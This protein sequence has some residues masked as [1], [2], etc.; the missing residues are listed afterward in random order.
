MASKH[1]LPYEMELFRTEDYYVMLNSISSLW[2]CRKT[3]E[4]KVKPG[5]ELANSGDLECL[6]IFY[7]LIGKIEFHIPSESRLILI[8]TVAPVGEIPGGRGTVHKICSIAFLHP[9]GPDATVTDM[10]LKFCRKHQTGNVN[11]PAA[12]AIVASPVFE[13]AS[14]VK[15]WGTI[16]SATSSIKNTTQQAAAI[17]SSQV[18]GNKKDKEK[19]KEKYEKRILDELY[20]IFTDTDS[21]YFSI[22]DAGGQTGDLTNTL[23][24]LSLIKQKS[25]GNSTQPVWKTVDDRFFWNKHM[26][27]DII[28]LNNPLADAWILPIIQG[29]VQI[30]SCKVDIGFDFVGDSCSF[31]P[32]YEVFTLALFSRRSRHRAGTRYKRRGVDENGN[33]ANYV[34]TEQIVCH[35]HHQVAFIQVRGSVPVFW[36]QP[37]YK[38]R[39]PPRIDK[40]EAETKIAF[41]K[42]F[43]EELGLYNTICIVNLVEQTGKEKI[44]WDAY[45]QHVLSYNSPDLTYVTFDFHEYCRGMRFENVS[46]LLNQMSDI[47]HEFGFCWQ[48]KQG[49]ICKQNGVFRVNC[50]DCL[51]RTNVVQTALGKAV[52]QIQMTKLGLMPPEGSLPHNLKKTFQL[53][54]ANNGDIISKQYAGTNALKGDYTRTGERKLSGMMKDGVNSAN[55]YYLSRFK[56][57]YRQA[58]I[59]IMQGFPVSEDIFSYER[60]DGEEDSNATAEHVKLLIEDCKK[61]LISDVSIVLGAWGLIDANPQ[62]GDPNETDMDTI[63]ILTKKSYYVAGYDEAIDQVTKYQRVLLSDVTLVELGMAE[64]LPQQSLS[65]NIFKGRSSKNS[66]LHYCL[67]LNYTVNGTPG[68]YH[69]FRSTNLRF[70]NN[71]AVVIRNEDEMI[72]SLRAISETF[73]VA[74]QI[75]NMTEVKVVHKDILERRTSRTLLSDELS[76]TGGKL[77]TTLQNR[78]TRNVSESQL[79]ALKNVGSKAITNVSQ[80][81]SK[82]NKLGHS[83]NARKRRHSKPSVENVTLKPA[84]S[85][86]QTDSS[87]VSS[88]EEEADEEDEHR[89]QKEGKIHLRKLSEIFLPTTGII[90]STTEIS[91]VQLI[92]C[93]TENITSESLNKVI[94]NDK[95]KKY[96]LLHSKTDLAIDVC[97]LDVTPDSSSSSRTPATTPEIVINKMSGTKVDSVMFSLQNEKTETSNN[98]RKTRQYSHSSGEVDVNELSEQDNSAKL[99][100]INDGIDGKRSTSE[101]DLILNIT[102]SQSE[103]ALRSIKSTASTVLSSPSAVF[104]P[105]SK[106]AKGVQTLGA[107]LDPHHPNFKLFCGTHLFINPQAK[108]FIGSGDVSGHAVGPP[109]LI[110]H[111]GKVLIKNMIISQ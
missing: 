65:L 56:D 67:R 18:K 48:D 99:S 63:L 58:T 66:G 79:H 23:Q 6:G 105:F 43:T 72:E 74:L 50:I 31:A 30:E 102:S 101:K 109:R 40:G 89:L 77:D 35:R 37:G 19:D 98:F 25:Q 80:Q 110:Q 14:F 45:T 71:V 51:D 17:A 5:W 42:H 107:N 69:M 87:R 59:D 86:Y 68:Y 62:S 49:L 16:K 103:N 75:A 54:W 34:E 1:Y 57:A 84:F 8:K 108:A 46:I 100:V 24:R 10:G 82:L 92:H 33:C 96:P 94:H 11:N 78:M 81:F 15:T 52:L 61:M 106:L 47:L 44:I 26:L 83:F 28:K 29:F 64:S 104:S 9:C 38:Y 90:M 76:N 2:C 39:P 20:R 93:D 27:K 13:K 21:F 95:V 97:R 111:P 4:I 22:V 32:K 12:G 7:G 60:G 73:E 91:P 53:L 85:L 88:E 3:G 36:S 41:A 55:R 70:F